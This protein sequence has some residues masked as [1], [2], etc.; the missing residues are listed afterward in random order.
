MT[1]LSTQMSSHYIPVEIR[2][3]Y[4]I[5]KINIVKEEWK[6]I[7]E[8][9]NY[10]ISNLGRFR[11]S[12]NKILKLNI[13]KRGYYYCNISINSKVSKIK[14]HR[15]VATHFC[16]NNQNKNT[17]NHKDKDKLNN[18]YTNLEWL[19]RKENIRH[20]HDLKY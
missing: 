18:L 13:N 16:K 11:N 19:T 8:S 17:V 20:Y 5:L 4:L 14:I 9:N 1:Y 15:L 10:Q 2:V 6:T 12:K 7:N 3:V